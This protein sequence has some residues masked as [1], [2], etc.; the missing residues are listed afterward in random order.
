MR[1]HMLLSPY[2]LAQN[3]FLICCPVIQQVLDFSSMGHWLFDICQVVTGISRRSIADRD[4]KKGWT[5]GLVLHCKPAVVKNDGVMG[6]SGHDLR[7]P[8]DD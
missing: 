5:M 4:E 7:S 8:D 1:A 6:G 2:Q 3:P